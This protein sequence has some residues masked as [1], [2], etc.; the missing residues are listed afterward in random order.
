MLYAPK[1]PPMDWNDDNVVKLKKLWAEGYSASEIADIF[2]LLS[3]SAV[4]GKIHRLGLCNRD[5]QKSHKV[6]KILTRGR[7]W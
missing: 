5:P 6:P 4:M 3:R 1:S 7:P 2:G